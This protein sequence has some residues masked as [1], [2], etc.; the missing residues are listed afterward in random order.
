MSCRQLAWDRFSE[1]VQVADGDLSFPGPCLCDE[2]GC[3]YAGHLAECSGGLVSF[4]SCSC[5]VR[6]VFC[7]LPFVN[8]EAEP[9]LHW[10]H[11]SLPPFPTLSEC[12]DLLP[13]EHH[14]RSQVNLETGS[15]MPG[16]LARWNRANQTAHQALTRRN[17]THP[18]CPPTL[19]L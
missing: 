1:R 18:S 19:P 6:L 13:W 17:E 9:R 4:S 15:L 14:A 3:R 10:S 8:Q 16:Q 11:V 7:H 12:P 5:L 2:P